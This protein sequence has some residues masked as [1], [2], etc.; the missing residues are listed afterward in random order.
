MAFTNNNRDRQIRQNKTVFRRTIYVLIIFAIWRYTYLF[1]WLFISILMGIV[2]L[3]GLTLPESDRTPAG[4]TWMMYTQGMLIE[5]FLFLPSD[6]EMIRNFR[7]HRAEIQRLLVMKQE[8]TAHRDYW[9]PIPEIE[10][11]KI[12]RRSDTTEWQSLMLVAGIHEVKVGGIWLPAPY[13]SDHRAKVNKLIDDSFS[14]DKVGERAR[15]VIAEQSTYEFKVSPRKT[16]RRFGSITKSYFYIPVAPTIEDGWLLSPPHSD[17][18]TPTR[19]RRKVSTLDWYWVYPWSFGSGN[20]IDRC[21]VRPLEEPH[22]Y[23]KLCTRN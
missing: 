19:E 10:G 12:G 1:H 16:S 23:L 14:T 17:S 11:R 22:W 2:Y 18:H 7:E 9:L 21:V 6:K 15:N 13:D 5:P 20:S 3:G 4:Y 8:D